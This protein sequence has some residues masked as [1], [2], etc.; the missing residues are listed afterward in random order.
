MA[1]VVTNGTYG[2][3]NGRGDIFLAVNIGDGQFGTSRA[4]LNGTVL[5]T[6]SGPMVIRI[7]PARDL[8]SKTLM[9]RSIVNDVNSQ[10]NRMSVTYR[11][12]GGSADQKT[13]AKGRASLDGDTLV[14]DT[15]FTLA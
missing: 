14:F 9:V 8:K 7:G 4:F 1:D 6:G 2:V 5:A 15:T 13:V 12:T 3:G 11:L 10:T